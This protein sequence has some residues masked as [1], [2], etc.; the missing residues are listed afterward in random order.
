MQYAMVWGGANGLTGEGPCGMTAYFQRWPL[1]HGGLWEV[2]GSPRMS[3][4][5]IGTRGG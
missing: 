5:G 2:L 4:M 1:V 3:E